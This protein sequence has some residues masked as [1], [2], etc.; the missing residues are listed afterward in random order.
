VAAVPDWVSPPTRPIVDPAGDGAETLSDGEIEKRRLQADREITAKAMVTNDPKRQRMGQPLARRLA[1]MEKSITFK[2]AS[3]AVHAQDPDHQSAVEQLVFFCNFTDP[4][5]LQRNDK[6]PPDAQIYAYL[7]IH[8][9]GQ[10]EWRVFEV[11]GPESHAY[12]AQPEGAGTNSGLGLPV[13]GR[14]QSPDH[15]E[16]AWFQ[17]F[18]GGYLAELKDQPGVIQRF[19]NDLT[20]HGEPFHDDQPVDLELKRRTVMRSDLVP[21]QYDT[22]YYSQQHY[23][24]GAGSACGC[25]TAAHYYVL[26]GWDEEQRYFLGNS[27]KARGQVLYGDLDEIDAGGGGVNGVLIAD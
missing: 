7:N 11:V 22:R 24:D 5:A 6:A 27:G 15:P 16:W 25:A 8:P 3:S 20:P 18:E 4:E 17:K 19:D 13:S 26:E 1:Q 14:E 23:L 10:E 21:Y 12:Q 2:G 9:E